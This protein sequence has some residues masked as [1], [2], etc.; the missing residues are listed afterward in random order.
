MSGDRPQRVLAFDY[1]LRHIGV[2]SGQTITGSA[3]PLPE[4]RANRGEP[5]WPAVV[6]LVR[7]W[8]PDV[9]LVGLPLNM[10]DTDNAITV[11]ARAFAVALRRH[12][13]L[14]VRLV[15]E[16]LSTRAAHD[17]LGAGREHRHHHGMAACVIAE[18]W[19]N[20]LQFPWP[21]AE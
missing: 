15:D 10:D 8:R 14:D 2:A 12:T 20:D 18:T 7:E 5:E 4:L 19:L 11:R 3:S 17:A 1:G 16:R 21:I 6:K 9:L 13:G